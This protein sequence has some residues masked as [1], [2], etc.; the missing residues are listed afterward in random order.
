MQNDIDYDG[1]LSISLQ[2]ALDNVPEPSFTDRGTVTIHSIRTGAVLIKQNPLTPEERTKIKVRFNY[3]AFCFCDT[4]VLV[5]LK[6]FNFPVRSHKGIRY[7]ITILYFYHFYRASRK[8]M[9]FT[10]YVPL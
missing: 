10:N 1:Q 8:V 3:N 6:I 7:C 9:V 4:V 2:H 5:T